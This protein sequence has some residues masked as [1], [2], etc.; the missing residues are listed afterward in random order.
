MS[1]DRRRAFY[2]QKGV[3]LRIHSTL[4]LL[5]FS[6]IAELIA[7]NATLL[8]QCKLLILAATAAARII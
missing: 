6:K 2:R 4:T 5:I 8:M 7:K 3:K 1:A